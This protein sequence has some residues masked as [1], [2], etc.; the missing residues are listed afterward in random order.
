MSTDG[1]MMN[2]GGV[3]EKAAEVARTAEGMKERVEYLV[4][5][6]R[7]VSEEWEGSTK[8]AFLFQEQRLRQAIVAL[9]EIQ[10]TTSVRATNA[11][12]A[13]QYIDRAGGRGFQGA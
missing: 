12:G 13:F 5:E 2:Y 9:S 8:E 6:V 1:T 3:T 4:G 11:M 7:R 10:N